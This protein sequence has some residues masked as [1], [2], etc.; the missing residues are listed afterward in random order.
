MT[1][2]PHVVIVGAG[3]AG[4]AAARVLAKAGSR[5]TLIDQHPYNTFQPLLYQV[6]TGGLNPGDI[7]YPLRTL[8]A[9]M[10]GRLRVRRSKVTEVRPDQNEVV[11]EDGA[12]IGYDHLII[13]IGVKANFFG[14]PGAE[15]YAM[16]LY[17]RAEALRVRDTMF[18]GL[19]RLAASPDAGSREFRT[20]VVG[21]GPTGVE[22][23]GT[24][25]EMR[26]V[27]LP[28]SFPE[29]DHDKVHV[30]LVEMA[31][32]LLSPFHK[33]LQRYAL[34]Q[35]AKRGVDVRLDTAISEVEP[36]RVQFKSGECLQADLVVWAG[37]VAGYRK[38]GRWGLE[39]GKG[40]RIVVGEDLRAVGQD[41]VWA[42]GDAAISDHEP[43]PQLAQP[44][45]QMGKHAA[46]QILRLEQ[47]QPTE[48][49]T[50]RDLGSMATIGQA[51]AVVEFPNGAR[52]TG[53]I[54]WVLWIFVH[55]MNLLGG[56]NRV[57][58][59][60]N[61]AA[62]YLAFRRTG[63]IVGDVRDPIGAREETQPVNVQTDDV[64]NEDA[65]HA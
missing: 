37:G 46:H 40:G 8:V 56:R 28:R 42:V 35:M 20:V 16:T 41:N 25:A 65:E 44:A 15:E 13:G 3:F 9:K 4:I 59:F 24:L 61:L 47:G 55:L 48:T 21:G 54:A 29:L 60:M 57:M 11:C 50:Y 36:G 23:A 2:L 31:P 27:A 43:L 49:F 52:F 53:L 34:E 1:N 19:E 14:I 26:D 30:T 64:V 63:G 6:A 38:V 62:R 17:T 7:T 51:S 5:V 10:H 12:T 18:G 33:N 32:Q 45:L 39:T 58:T 22:M